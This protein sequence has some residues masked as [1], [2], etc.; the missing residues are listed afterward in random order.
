MADTSHVPASQI[1]EVA[2]ELAAIGEEFGCARDAAESNEDYGD[3]IIAY[4]ENMIEE[5]LTLQDRVR[6]LVG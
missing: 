1:P 2:H 5:L 4:L 6:E 3:R